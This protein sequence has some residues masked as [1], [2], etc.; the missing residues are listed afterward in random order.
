MDAD[1]IL[2]RDGVNA[3]K[4]RLWE[5]C[6]ALPQRD[7]IDATDAQEW[8]DYMAHIMPAEASWHMTR[9]GGV[10]GSEIGGLVRNYLGQTADHGFSANKWAQD[11]LLRRVPDLPKGVTARGHFM[12]PLIAQ[13]LYEELGAQ[14]DD[15]AFAALTNASSRY[16]WMRYSPDDLIILARPTTIRVGAADENHQEVLDGRILVDYKAPTVVDQTSRIAFQYACQLHQGALLCIEND[17]DINGVMLT[18]FDWA[19]FA[20]KNDVVPID[21]ELLELIPVVGEHYWNYVLRGEVPAPIY[22]KRFD[23]EPKDHDLWLPAA[24]RLA[25]I[26]AMRTKLD[27]ESEELR[28]KLNEGLRLNE[29]RLDDARIVFQGALTISGRFKLDEEKIRGALTPEE[30]ES[31]SVKETTVQYDDKGLAEALKSLGGD[32]RLYRKKVKI[33]TGLAIDMLISKNIDPE[34]F[35]SES[36]A[37]R[38]D[39]SIKDQAHD[40][41]N[42][43]FEPLQLPKPIEIAALDIPEVHTSAPARPSV[44]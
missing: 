42:S 14:R 40:W 22:K 8:I 26:N 3:L 30:I 28:K 16:S 20:L 1:N 38:V 6:D 15:A 35:V 12:E 9:A 18:Q 4:K 31:I 29:V 33:D 7:A 36:A 5:K 2:D 24:T 41:F 19:N 37:V 27:N 21:P 17:I 25:Q 11:K 39:P 10:G 34:G 13:R 23:L 43:S 44:A 32:P